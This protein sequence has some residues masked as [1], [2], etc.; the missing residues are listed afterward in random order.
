MVTATPPKRK[1]AVDPIRELFTFSPFGLGCRECKI[2]ASIQLEERCIR[3]HLKKHVMTSSIV[4]VRSLLDM[5]RAELEFAKASG[6][7]EP[8]GRVLYM[9]A[10]L[11]ILDLC[12]R[13]NWYNHYHTIIMKITDDFVCILSRCVSFGGWLYNILRL[14]LASASRV[15][16]Y[17]LNDLRW[18]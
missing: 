8:K 11:R 3:D 14:Y 5:F 2:N 9:G 4:V 15:S 17:K 18:S 10:T 1:V 6:T 12:T 7:I 16:E 13:H